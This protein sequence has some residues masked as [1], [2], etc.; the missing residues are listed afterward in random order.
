MLS[1]IEVPAENLAAIDHQDTI[2]GGG[3]LS[4]SLA[5]H[6]AAPGSNLCCPKNFSL[7]VVAI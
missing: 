7:D 4:T 6:P 2:H 5:S 1:C 3:L